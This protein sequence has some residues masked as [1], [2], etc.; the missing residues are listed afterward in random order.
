MLQTAEGIR[1][2][3]RGLREMLEDYE[4]SL[5]AS[6]LQA[7]GGNQRRAA[8]ALGVLPSTLCE[9]MKRLGLRSRAIYSAVPPEEL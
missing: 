2:G 9:K 7:A 5:I 3:G 4:R 8:R 1:V 6:A